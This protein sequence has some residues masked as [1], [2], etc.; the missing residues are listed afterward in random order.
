VDIYS[1]DNK[2]L[3]SNQK[4]KPNSSNPGVYNYTFTADK[5]FDTGKAFTFIMTEPVTDGFEVGSGMVE[6]M[7]L[8]TIAGLASAA[9]QAEQTAKKALDAIKAVEAVLVTGE[10]INI[11]MTLK[12]LKDSVDAL[13]A[14]L[15]KEGPSARLN[16]TVDEISDRL[17]ALGGKEGF[18]LSS[19][20][21]K[22]L[23]NSPTVRDMRTKT[24][25]IGSV[26]EILKQIFEAKFGGKDAP[27]VSTTLAPGSVKFRIVAVNPSPTKTQKV[28]VKY[29]LPGEVKP[30]DIVDLGGLDLEYDSARSIHY[31][32]KTDL[33]LVPGE[34]RVF[35]VDVEDIW[36]V[37]QDKIAD[38]KGRV[39]QILARL[40]QTPYYSKAKEIS[41]TIYPKLNDIL[42]SQADDAV[43]RE[44]H[45]G[46]YRQNL[47]VLAQVKED[48]ARMEKILVT[49]GGPP[50]PEMLA[51]TK[52][53]ADEPN[54]TMTWIIIFVI[55]IF[56][57]L[58]A[59]VLFFSWNRQSRIVKDELSEAKNSAFPESG[60]GP[61]EENKPEEGQS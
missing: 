15:A 52:I 5:R 29:D 13:P 16:T 50:S 34:V 48:I 39:D 26:I 27:V 18:D 53:K 31:V 1:W 6:S 12:N 4:F 30:K 46:I 3:F 10:N 7:S 57:G 44:R 59:G 36:L 33:E 38:L 21:E 2:I 41:D 58:L 47:E 55:I 51:K 8:T 32:Y 42:T 43:S 24:D 20:F 49:A 17:K 40:E 45:I 60:S 25:E 61:E 35:E 19:L 14:E 28:Q 56:T 11:A 23:S 9:P 54:K 37:G 22:A